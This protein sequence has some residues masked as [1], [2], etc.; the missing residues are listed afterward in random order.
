MFRSIKNFNPYS[1]P[2]KVSPHLEKDRL[3]LHIRPFLR[4]NPGQIRLKKFY[5]RTARDFIKQMRIGDG[6][7]NKI[8]GQSNILFND[9]ISSHFLRPLIY[10]SL[11]HCQR[12]LISCS[13]LYTHALTS[14]FFLKQHL[15]GRHDFPDEAIFS[16]EGVLDL[17]GSSN[18]EIHREWPAGEEP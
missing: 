15:A 17:P 9:F 10:R 1:N 8:K 6:C 11:Y 4:F 2:L 12:S 13:A 5:L 7:T 14:L 18:D 16:N 3:P